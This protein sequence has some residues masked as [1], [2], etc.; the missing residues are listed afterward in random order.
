M[1]L[2]QSLSESL[3]CGSLAIPQIHILIFR[4]ANATGNPHLRPI[5]QIMGEFYVITDTLSRPKVFGFLGGSPLL[6]DKLEKLLDAKV[7]VHRSMVVEEDNQPPQRLSEL[8]MF[9][10][11]HLNRTETSLMRTLHLLDPSETV[12]RS[13]FYNAKLTLASLGHCASDLIWRRAF[14]EID[15]TLPSMYDDDNGDDDNDNGDSQAD[16]LLKTKINIRNSIKNW[17]FAMPNL[18]KSSRG[19]NVSSKLLK[20]IQ[21]LNA[22]KPE[23]DIFRGIVFGMYD[24]HIMGIGL[25]LID[26]K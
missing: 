14:K 21:I 16:R 6:A 2:V 19:F 3:A 17:V 11:P 7:Y 13:H 20:L 26:G 8:V 18:D 5:H 22:C 15:S 23:G 12:F 1:Y 25:F 9:Y 24:R 10:E 4:D